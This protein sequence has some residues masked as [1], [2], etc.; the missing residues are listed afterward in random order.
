MLSKIFKTFFIFFITSNFIIFFIELNNFKEHI[1]SSTKYNKKDSHNIVILTGGTN[2]IKDGLKI[3]K[4]FRKSKKKFYKILVSGTGAGF[5]K[6]SLKKQLGPNFNPH[7]IKCCIDLDNV[8]KNTF[9]NASE[10]FKWTQKKKI[11]EFTLIT[12]NYH[13]P[14]AFL[15]FKYIMP[16]LKIHTYAIIPKKHDIENWLSSYQTF[17][18]VLT[19]YCKYIVANLRIKFFGSKFISYI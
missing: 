2:R 7:L 4:D 9:T 16:N 13:M 17:G 11:K 8:S 12:S 18:L 10:T 1:L 5:T 15:E 14:R 6:N 3:I 19:E